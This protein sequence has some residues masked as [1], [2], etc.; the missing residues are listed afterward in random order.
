MWLDRL[1]MSGDVCGQAQ[2]PPV[3]ASDMMLEPTWQALYY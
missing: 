2:S 1:T 3:A